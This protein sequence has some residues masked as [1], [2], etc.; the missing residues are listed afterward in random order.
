M[1][2]VVAGSLLDESHK[3]Y[4]P[5]R[6][7][8]YSPGEHRSTAWN[9]LVINQNTWNQCSEDHKEQ[10]KLGYRATVQ[11]TM[12]ETIPSQIGALERMKANGDVEVR[13]F[14]PELI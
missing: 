3:F 4:Q 11:R 1:A 8:Y 13:Q 5:A 7:Y 10:L 14:P 2:D 12:A 6:Q 9:S